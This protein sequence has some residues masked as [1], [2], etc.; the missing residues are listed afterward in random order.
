MINEVNDLMKKIIN[1]LIF[2]S[3]NIEKNDLNL[4]NDKDCLMKVFEFLREYKMADP[5]DFLK[6]NVILI[7]IEN[8]PWKND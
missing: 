5:I 3:K 7:I 1:Y 6:V 4:D 8:Y 2:I